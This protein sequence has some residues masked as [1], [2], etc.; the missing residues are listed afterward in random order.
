MPLTSRLLSALIVAR[1]FITGLIILSFADLIRSPATTGLLPLISLALAAAILALLEYLLPPYLRAR[2]EK[3]WRARLAQSRFA[4]PDIDTALAASDKYLTA[5][6]SVE[7]AA[8][9]ETEFLGPLRAAMVA[10]VAIIL[11]VGLKISWLAALIMSLGSLVVPLI[12]FWAIKTLRGAGAGYGRASGQLAGSFLSSV[13][14]LQSILVL[15]AATQRRQI[16][17]S[18]AE[19]IRRQV[20]GLLY[21]NQAMILVTDGSFGLLVMAST[22]AVSVSGLAAGRYDAPTA[23]ALIL[24]AR[25]LIDPVN[26]MGRTFYTGMSGKAALNRLK[27]QLPASQAITMPAAAEIKTQAPSIRVQ[28]LGVSRK[29]DGKLKE[30]IKNLNLE[31]PAGYHTAII[32]PSGVGK[33]SLGLALAGLLPYQGT[34]M[35]DAQP[36]T[37]QQLRQLVS[38]MPQ[39]ATLFSGSL[40]ENIDLAGKGLDIAEIQDSLT[41]AAL[42]LDPAT[43]IGET[44]RRGL[45]GGQAA[46][47]ALARAHAKGAKIFV[48][49]EP[50]AQLDI[51]TAAEV[52]NT[53]KALGITL[54]EITHRI[55]E[56]NESQQIIALKNGELVEAA[57]FQNAAAQ[58][59]ILEKTEETQK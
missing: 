11:L 35:V 32:G 43:L 29:S 36:V 45:S 18:L 19:N 44:N 4:A 34:I 9:Y 50:V 3:Y 12:I 30:V 40:A 10:P 56:A 58:A 14:H 38:Y 51:Q 5:T 47:V 15:N 42:D 17:S 20:M 23:V 54:I 52:R 57:S 31:I 59:E 22:A 6:E 33:S 26:A 46:R 41:A 7:K 55:T 28:N 49:D 16:I 1:V 24:L 37:A 13:R 8:S 25:L 21:K 2:R 27:S 39:Q 53:A 48:L